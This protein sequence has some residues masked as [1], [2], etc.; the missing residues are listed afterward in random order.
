M[1]YPA[2]WIGCQP[3]HIEPNAVRRT[4]NQAEHLTDRARMKQQWAN[5]L[6]AW[7]RGDDKV[8][9]IKHSAAA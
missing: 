6:D 1:G 4:Y 9:P 5:M 7:Q 2:D 8:T 3:A